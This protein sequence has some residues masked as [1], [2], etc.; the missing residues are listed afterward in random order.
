MS[1]RISHIPFYGRMPIRDK[2]LFIWSLAFAVILAALMYWKP[3]FG[4]AFGLAPLVLLLVSH[5]Q[6]VIY[7]LI[8]AT[9]LFLPMDVGLVLLPAD[10]AAAVLVAAYLLDVLVRGPSRHGNPLARPFFLYTGVVLLSIALEGFTAL[11]VR[12]LLRQIL[13]LATFLAV[14]HFGHRINVKR[15]LLVFM[16]AAIANSCYSVMQF[17]ALGGSTRAFGLAGRGYGDHAML[18]FLI[19]VIFYL[20]S[21]DIRSRIFWGF[22]SLLMVGAV[23]ATQ[24]RASALTA[25]WGLVVIIP[26]AL[27]A[28]KRLLNNV[29]RKG[30]WAAIV[31]GILILPLLVLYTPLFEGIMDRFARMGFQATGTILLRLSLWKAALAAFWANPIFGIGAGNFAQVWNWVPGVKFD[32]IFYLVSGLGTHV[33]IMN[34]LAETGILG[35]IALLYFFV[36]A[37]RVSY[38]HYVASLHSDKM[39]I[40]IS[41]FIIALVVFGSSFYAGSWFWGNNSYHM[42]VF[43]GLIASYIPRP[44]P[45]L[46]SVTAW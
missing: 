13:L 41:L 25:M 3:M 4:I 38:H 2:T 17:L 46:S 15:V 19:S 28:G 45:A 43:F 26:L 10:I 7:L 16:A 42:A 36:R 23:A 1:T 40:A 11:S 8:A 35:V 9:F 22:S 18:G 14:A 5:G 12:Y 37:I 30:L 27:R 21:S 34:A 6:S 44:A 29:P 31:L 39:P 33:V 32:P 24:T 20:W